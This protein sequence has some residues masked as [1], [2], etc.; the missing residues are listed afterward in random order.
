MRFPFHNSTIEKKEFLLYLFPCMNRMYN[1]LHLTFTKAS[2]YTNVPF[3][4]K[5]INLCPFIIFQYYMLYIYLNNGTIITIPYATHI[6]HIFFLHSCM[7]SLYHFYDGLFKFS[8]RKSKP[9]VKY[10]SNI[11]NNLLSINWNCHIYH[12]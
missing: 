11:P 2:K 6:I 8:Y 5:I 12:L 4:R 1:D 7:Q 9:H 3:C 10:D